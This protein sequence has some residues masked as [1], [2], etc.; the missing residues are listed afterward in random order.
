[1]LTT[2]E[3]KLTELMNALDED[4]HPKTPIDSVSGKTGPTYD[5]YKAGEFIYSITV[6]TNLTKPTKA[7]IHMQWPRFHM[8]VRSLKARGKQLDWSTSTVKSE[9]DQ[10]HVTVEEKGSSINYTA[11]IDAKTLRDLLWLEKSIV[12]DDK[13]TVEEL[14]EAVQINECL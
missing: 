13:L 7:N 9:P 5:P 3:T 8:L 1:M 12:A 6:R 4:L 11:I 10:V 14:F 2:I